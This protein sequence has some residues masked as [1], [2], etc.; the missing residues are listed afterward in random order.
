MT[1]PLRS[2]ITYADMI[3]IL[4]AIIV[5]GCLYQQF[6][7]GGEGKANLAVI[8]NP[9]SPPAEINL[10]QGQH[11]DIQGSLGLSQLQVKDGKIRFL[12]SPCQNKLCIRSGWLE[13]DGE[14]AACLPNRVSIHLA[15]HGNRTFDAI[16]F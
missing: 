7:Q 12:S 15:G 11:L 1:S 5:V 16:N 8:R 14:A 4:A 10:N 3:V 2:V 9:N 13:H 6:W